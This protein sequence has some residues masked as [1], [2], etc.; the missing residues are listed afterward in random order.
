MTNAKLLKEKI[1]ASGVTITFLADKLGCSRNRIYSILEGSECTASE[2]VGL[3]EA[4]HLTK[5][6]RDTI[7]LSEKVIDNH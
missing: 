3:S 2:I 7:F 6:E 5:E 1:T 4:I